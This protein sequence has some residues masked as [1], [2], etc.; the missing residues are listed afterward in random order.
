MKP[1]PTVSGS[2]PQ[3][4]P[5]GCPCGGRRE[6]WPVAEVRLALNGDEVTTPCFIAPDGPAVPGAVA[7]ESPFFAVDPA[8]RRLVPAEGFIG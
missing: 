7:L 8:V 5:P 3:T 1:L 2:Y 4:H 6:P